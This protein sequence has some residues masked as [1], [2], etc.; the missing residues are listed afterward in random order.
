MAFTITIDDKLNLIIVLLIVVLWYVMFVR[1]GYATTLECAACLQKLDK[2]RACTQINGYFIPQGCDG[3]AS[4]NK[5][6]IDSRIKYGSN[7]CNTL[8]PPLPCDG[9]EPAPPR[10]DCTAATQFVYVHNINGGGDGS[11]DGSV[12]TDESGR[13]Y[14]QEAQCPADNEVVDKQVSGKDEEK[15]FTYKCC[16]L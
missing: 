13:M 5:L 3:D 10:G 7:L 14:T 16:P 15:L 4:A 2:A 12:Y 6:L 1:E 8:S 11:D 9:G